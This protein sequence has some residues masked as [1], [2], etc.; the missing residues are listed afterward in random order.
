MP[1]ARGGRSQSQRKSIAKKN[2]S[3]AA[4]AA[5]KKVARLNKGIA[6]SGSGKRAADNNHGRSQRVDKIN[7]RKTKKGY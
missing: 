4:S 1:Q 6:S 5:T 7:R 2:P 3:R